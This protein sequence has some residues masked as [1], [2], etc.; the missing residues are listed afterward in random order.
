MARRPQHNSNSDNDDIGTYARFDGEQVLR[1]ELSSPE[2]LKQL[3]A[4]VEEHNLDLWSNL[5]IGNV[6]VRVPSDKLEAFKAATSTIPSTVMIPNLQDL[7][8]EHAPA[9]LLHTKQQNNW[10]FTDNSFWHNYHDF[11]TLNN[12]TEAMVQQY[13]DL[14][15]RISIGHTYEGREIFGMSIHGFKPKKKKK[16]DLS[17]HHS[18]DVD[19]EEDDDEEVDMEEKNKK[20]TSWRSWIPG[21]ARRMAKKPSK[22]KKHPKAIIIHA[23]QHA[24]EW[25]GPAVVTYIAK[26]LILGYRNNKKITRLVNQFE[27][28]IVPLLNADGYVYT[29][30]TNRMWRKNRQPTSIPLCPGVDPNR[31]WGYMWNTG[32]G[33][34][35]PCSEGYTGPEAFAAHEAKMMA[36][37]ISKRKNVIAYLDFHAYAQLW[38]SPFGED[39]SKIPRDDE[40]I[41]EASMG[42]VKALQ[43]VNGKKF[44]VGSICNVFERTTGNSIDWT[45]GVANVKYSYFVELRDTGL[46]GFLL[47]ESEILPSSEETMAAVTYLSNFIRIREKQWGNLD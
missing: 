17:D 34:S 26:E 35:N 43:N 39:C 13:P 20:F 7:V 25:I 11:E 36:D 30:E 47:P 3:E 37:Y 31:S 2:Q 5:R 27:F 28:V 46:Y 40:D 16:A 45:Y 32:G 14:V 29:W 15:K 38:M 33:S 6:D 4:I 21:H 18:W 44:T 42:A 23:G 12:F 19:E 24:R 41:V 22:P 9:S 1:M 10:N 8:P